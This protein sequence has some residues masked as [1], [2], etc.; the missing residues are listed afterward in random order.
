VA[1]DRDTMIPSSRTKLTY[2]D[3]LLFPDVTLA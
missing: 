1:D 3:L 2:E